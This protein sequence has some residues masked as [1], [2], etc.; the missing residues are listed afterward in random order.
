MEMKYVEDPKLNEKVAEI[1]EELKNEIISHFHPK[2][3]ILSGSFGRGEATVIEENGKLNFLS[4]CEIL[5]VPYKWI[6]SRKKLDEFEQNFYRRT[7]LKVEIWGLFPCALTRAKPTIANYDLKH[8]SKILYGKNYLEKIPDFKPED[9]PLWEGI[10][11]MLNRMAEALE[12]FSLENPTTEMIFWTDKIVIACQ[13]ALLLSIG[14]YHPLLRKRSDLFVEYSSIFRKIHPKILEIVR[15]AVK[16]KLS[17][18]TDHC[19]ID[20]AIS[21]WYETSEI[22]DKVFRYLIKKYWG[23][24]FRDY[25]DFHTKYLKKV[26]RP[27]LAPQNFI[28]YLKLLM[29]YKLNNPLPLKSLKSRAPFEH[30]IYSIIPLAYFDLCGKSDVSEKHLNCVHKVLAYF[31]VNYEPNPR[32]CVKEIVRLWKII[33]A[34]IKMREARP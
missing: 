16:R 14:K 6:F 3:I 19:Y 32:K 12:Y 18:K 28:K 10:R 33:F 15:R 9:I 2:S 20:E 30:L 24:E 5:L 4:D 1:I 26:M 13:D 29:L 27:F 23:I 31:G 34:P 7:G 21:Y 8:G 11:L 22:A 17:G 25:L